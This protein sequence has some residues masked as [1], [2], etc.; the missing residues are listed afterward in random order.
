M[1]SRL[2]QERDRLRTYEEKAQETKDMLRKNTV[3]VMEV[4]D[5]DTDVVI[6]GLDGAG[7]AHEGVQQDMTEMK[8][9]DDGKAFGISLKDI[10]SMQLSTTEQKEKTGT[11]G[12]DVTVDDDEEV[13]STR[14][15]LSAKKAV[16][17]GRPKKRDASKHL[18]MTPLT[19]AQ[20]MDL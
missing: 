20:T 14:Q 12:D 4:A 16:K 13:D 15:P 3:T 17:R 2:Q 11:T 18:P 1:E 10:E 9:E 7:A 5:N 6:N 8:V 19:V